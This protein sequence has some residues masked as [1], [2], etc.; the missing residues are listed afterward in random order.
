VDDVRADTV[1]E[2]L[3]VRNQNQDPL[4]AAMGQNIENEF[5]HILKP[6]V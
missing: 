1:Q 4:V 6:T 3:R 5:R 2:I